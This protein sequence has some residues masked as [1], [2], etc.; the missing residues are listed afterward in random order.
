MAAFELVLLIASAVCSTVAIIVF[1]C[2]KDPQEL[3]GIA[4]KR[5]EWRLM[6]I[7]FTEWL[8][9]AIIHSF[10]KEYILHEGPDA[11][12]ASAYLLYWVYPKYAM[13]AYVCSAAITYLCLSSELRKAIMMIFGWKPTIITNQMDAAGASDGNPCPIT[14]SG[15]VELQ[16]REPIMRF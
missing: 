15:T 13:L 9:A 2:R 10:Y 16:P 14:D 11:L 5:L 1:R 8:F 12:G 3:S 4:H 6:L 7:S